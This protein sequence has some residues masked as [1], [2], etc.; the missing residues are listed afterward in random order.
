[1]NTELTD[2]TFSHNASQRELWSKM[3]AAAASHILDRTGQ[4]AITSA[5]PGVGTSNDAVLYRSDTRILQSVI[6]R[7]A[8]ELTDDDLIQAAG[9]VARQLHPLMSDGIRDLSQIDHACDQLDDMIRASGRGLPALKTLPREVEIDQPHRRLDLEEELLLAVD[10]G[11]AEGARIDALALSA[12]AGDHDA[13]AE[14][15]RSAAAATADALASLRLRQEETS[16]TF[17]EADLGFHVRTVEAAAAW[18]QGHPTLTALLTQ[19]HNVPVDS[20]IPDTLSV[21]KMHDARCHVLYDQQFGVANP[22]RSPEALDAYV[23]LTAREQA[24][25]VQIGQHTSSFNASSAR[26][27]KLQLTSQERDFLASELHRYADY[28]GQ[29]TDFTSGVVGAAD[30]LAEEVQRSGVI[31]LSNSNKRSLVNDM[32]CNAGWEFYP[33][34]RPEDVAFS[35]PPAELVRVI[36]AEYAAGMLARRARNASF[37]GAASASQGSPPPHTI[38]GSRATLRTPPTRDVHER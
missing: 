14:L 7:G 16:A 3:T 35:P 26:D 32:L 4:G 31:D 2:I 8:R 34:A 11:E 15:E 1:M 24:T 18:S 9:I 19:Q 28:V 10:R 17:F 38:S 21:L 30:G 33:R 12:V 6:D 37:P 13:R 20:A 27:F 25:A 29:M 36:A 22:V 5:Y 23:V